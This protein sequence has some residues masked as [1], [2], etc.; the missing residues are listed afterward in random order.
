LTQPCLDADKAWRIV[1]LPP[2]ERRA[3]KF[4]SASRPAVQQGYLTAF[5][6]L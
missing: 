3:Q 4:H 6:C 5:A 1:F 2:Y